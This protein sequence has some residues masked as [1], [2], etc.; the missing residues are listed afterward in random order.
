MRTVV[1]L[2]IEK[3][4][5]EEYVNKLNPHFKRTKRNTHFRAFVLGLARSLMFFAFSACMYYGGILIR[6]DGIAYSDVFK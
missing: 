4:F 6:D 2:G 1:S 5:N 3:S